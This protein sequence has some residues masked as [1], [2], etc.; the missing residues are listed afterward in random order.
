MPDHKPSR[1]LPKKSKRERRRYVLF[2]VDSAGWLDGRLL[3]IAIRDSFN[4]MFGAEGKA[5]IHPVLVKFW[6]EKSRGILRCPR[7]CEEK[8][9]KAL[10][11]L[12]E[13]GGKPLKARSL[14]CSGSLK[15]LRQSI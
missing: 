4:S 8:A 6:P 15:A 9:R 13:A 3:W 2:E 7:G 1:K 14:R 11:S 12:E 10:E 5:E